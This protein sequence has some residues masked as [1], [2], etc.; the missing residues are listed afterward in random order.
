MLGA[1]ISITTG[2]DGDKNAATSAINNLTK[3][4]GTT[5]NTL[6]TTA[7]NLTTEKQNHADD[8]SFANDQ[9]GKANAYEQTF[10]IIHTGCYLFFISR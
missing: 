9:I 3:Q 10:C 6:G 5:A 2:F 1:A 7:Q 4:L 8:V